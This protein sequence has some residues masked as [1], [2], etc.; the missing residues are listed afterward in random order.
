[1]RRRV[2]ILL[3]L[4]LGV[5]VAAEV[6][7]AGDHAAGACPVGSWD[8]KTGANEIWWKA[9]TSCTDHPAEE[10]VHDICLQV[11]DWNTW[12][13]RDRYVWGVIFGESSYNSGFI[14][15][16]RFRTVEDYRGLLC[17]RIRTYHR[18]IEHSKRLLGE[19]YSYSLGQC[20]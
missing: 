18:V 7:A 1:M 4:L 16:S 8:N 9:V 12:A 19:G 2:A 5:L 15:E 11:F 6:L 13:W 20:F 14:A 3:V 17:Y 10:L